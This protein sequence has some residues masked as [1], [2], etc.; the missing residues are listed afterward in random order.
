MKGGSAWVAHASRVSASASS[1][2]RTFPLL[3]SRKSVTRSKEKIV[4]ARRRNQHAGRVRYPIQSA[5]R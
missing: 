5:A 3:P 1:R 4:S 2:S